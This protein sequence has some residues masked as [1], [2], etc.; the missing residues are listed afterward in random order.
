MRRIVGW[1]AFTVGQVLERRA[2]EQQGFTRIAAPNG[3]D[4]VTTLSILFEVLGP[5]S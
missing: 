5:D 4:A 2:M 1:I 3:V